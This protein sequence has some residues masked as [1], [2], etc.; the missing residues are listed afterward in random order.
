MD[1]ADLLECSICLEQLDESNK[2]L[3]CQHT[4][5]TK[6]LK[7]IFKKK[8]E[9]LCPECRK[10]VTVTIDSLPP[11]ILAN[12]ILEGMNIARAKSG[13]QLL[14]PVVTQGQHHPAL[15]L[16]KRPST[17]STESSLTRK[18]KS[19]AEDN[20][21]HT[22]Q[23]S[24]SSAH[25]GIVQPNGLV[26]MST[27]GPTPTTSTPSIN[28]ATIP[29]KKPQ[30]PLLPTSQTAIT[31]TYPQQTTSQSA[32]FSTAT[33][34]VLLSSLATPGIIPGSISNKPLASK[35][36]PTN[37]S[38]IPGNLSTNPFLDLINADP[39]MEKHKQEVKETDKTNLLS[40]TFTGL[41]LP[42]AKKQSTQSA[43][44]N[45]LNTTTTIAPSTRPTPTN[46]LTTTN[47]QNLIQSLPLPARPAPKP[48]G[49]TPASQPPKVPDRPKHT[50]TD[51]LESTKQ[52][53]LSP[54]ALIDP[55]VST[56]KTKVDKT[57]QVV[58]NTSTTTR[59]VYRAHYEYKSNQQDELSLKKGELYLVTD[60]CHDG[61]FKGQNLKT[62]A[63]G[64]FPG[65]HV[66]PHD[67]TKKGKKEAREVNL[68]DLGEGVASET[69]AERL[70][71]LRKIRDT[72]R[73]NQQQNVAR[74]QSS[75]VGG[76]AVGQVKSKVERYRCVV[77]FPAST[78]YELGLQLGDV[79]SLVK[80]R[81]DGWCK[82][83][84]HRTGKTGLFPASFVEKI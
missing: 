32:S 56:N 15:P 22:T 66:Q 72:L 25:I 77:A 48:P 42:Q 82:G 40:Q 64:V 78:E 53:Q 65:N 30:A 41:K 26:R 36:P 1:L 12:R 81:D 37:A 58:A 69:D 73:Q 62:G 19:P 6:C 29:I 13:S 44:K 60:Q 35:V 46:V 57:A 17:K 71:K 84:L 3:P 47:D 50:L 76:G 52:W 14:E 23:P 75:S 24:H 61:W 10:P 80:R 74:T 43:I 68:I 67:N 18:P 2:V 9:L 51:G 55:P 63:T 8:G 7:D 70:E 38:S 79:I 33:T 20:N 49:T 4:F 59:A 34:T 83:T 54:R 28:K 39:D 21:L 11:N 5:C 31:N 27:V 45:V 16:P